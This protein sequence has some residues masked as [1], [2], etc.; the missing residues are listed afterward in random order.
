MG[1]FLDIALQEMHRLDDVERMR[2][3]FRAQEEAR[4]ALAGIIDSLGG[5]IRV[6]RKYL[7]ASDYI[8]VSEDPI[9]GDFIY[10]TRRKE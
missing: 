10:R 2:I 5:E 9:T 1:E 7:V 4:R 8:E 3:Q 6:Q